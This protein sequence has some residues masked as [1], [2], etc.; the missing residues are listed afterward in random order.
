MPALDKAALIRYVDCLLRSFG[1]L[2][3][4]ISFILLPLLDFVCVLPE[5]ASFYSFMK[6]LL[7]FLVIGY[8]STFFEGEILFFDILR[9]LKL[10]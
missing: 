2:L 3:S 9:L 6:V 1:R 4:S 10:S 7:L 5:L 8:S